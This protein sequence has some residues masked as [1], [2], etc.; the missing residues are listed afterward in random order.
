MNSF[1]RRKTSLTLDATLLDDAKALGLNVSAVADDALRSAVAAA[2]HDAWLHENEAAFAAQ[3]AWH[4]THG[5]PL[6]DIMAG[7]GAA[8]WKR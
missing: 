8:T 2:R 6:A 5:H 4:E 1:S 7:P 3:R